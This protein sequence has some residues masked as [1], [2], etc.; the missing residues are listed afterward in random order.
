[1]YALTWMTYFPA[2]L[3][4]GES[5]CKAFN[6]SAENLKF[7]WESLT[8]KPTLTHSELP[9]QFS[10]QSVVELK[11]L[12]Q[13]E[14]SSAAAKRKNARNAPQMAAKRSAQLPT[15]GNRNAART[16]FAATPGATMVKSEYMA[17]DLSGPGVA[18]PSN[19]RF[20][21]PRNDA[22]SKKQRACE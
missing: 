19:V 18:G 2:D 13:N 12:L 7:K 16:A 11:A 22:S 4:P 6:I 14:L 9:T 1:M 3:S 21:G 5:L 17:V 8:Y 20:E 10:M 15:F